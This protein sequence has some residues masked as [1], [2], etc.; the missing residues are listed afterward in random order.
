MILRHFDSFY[1]FNYISINYYTTKQRKL[2]YIYFVP[3]ICQI[4]DSNFL[5]IIMLI[6]CSAP[7]RLMSI[8][9]S[10]FNRL[11]TICNLLQI[12][13]V[14]FEKIIPELH[15]TTIWILAQFHSTI[16]Q[17]HIVEMV[18]GN[19]VY[20]WSVLVQCWITKKLKIN[21]TILHYIIY[22]QFE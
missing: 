14:F 15:S 21:Q 10:I 13:I 9:H 18:L 3:S 11:R 7:R 2:I 5:T 1:I 8:A 22:E 6:A 12:K 16:G 20:L 4:F 19:R 17:M